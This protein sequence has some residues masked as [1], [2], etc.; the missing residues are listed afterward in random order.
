VKANA[1]LNACNAS[2]GV[3]LHDLLD[4]RPSRQ[5]ADDFTAR[6]RRPVRLINRA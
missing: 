4:A 1:T 2:L 6:D 3:A 5:Q